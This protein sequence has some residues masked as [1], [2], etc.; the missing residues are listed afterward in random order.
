[1]V[2]FSSR[3]S[4]VERLANQRATLDTFRDLATMF[5]LQYD[6]VWCEQR[7]LLL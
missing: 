6:F 5:Q 4:W 1:M 2:A 3:F 7:A